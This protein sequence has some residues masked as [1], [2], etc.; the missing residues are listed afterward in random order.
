[1]AG[2]FV[3]FLRIKPHARSTH[4]FPGSV[5]G[6]DDQSPA[7]HAQPWPLKPGSQYDARARVVMRCIHYVTTRTPAMR[8]DTRHD[9]RLELISI[10][11]FFC[12]AMRCVTI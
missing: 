9:A 2:A 10:R 1:M 8:R 5:V 6:S 3:F 4:P 12:V 11:A 7:F